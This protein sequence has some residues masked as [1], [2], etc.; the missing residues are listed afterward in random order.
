MTGQSIRIRLRPPSRTFEFA[1]V[2]GI[3]T[4]YRF[5]WSSSSSPFMTGL[6]AGAYASAPDPYLPVY[7]NGTLAYGQT[8]STTADTSC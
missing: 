4:D 7:L 1:F 2:D 3:G 8:P 6:A 5:H